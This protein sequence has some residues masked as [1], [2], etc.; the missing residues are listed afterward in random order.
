[1]ARKATRN[2]QGGGTIRQRSDG[3]WEARY[4]VGKDPGTGKQLQK[5]IYGDSQAEV[6]RLLTAALREIDKGTYIPPQK[7][8]LSNWLDTWL[9]EYV[10]NSVKPNTY[11]AYKAQV[12]K[13]IKPALGATEIQAL[14]PHSIQTFYNQ[15]LAEGQQVKVKDD[16]K[17]VHVENRPMSPK[18]VHNIHGVLTKALSVATRL[19]Y[20]HANPA[21]ACELPRQV[22]KTVQP[23]NEADIKRFL[24]DL[25]NDPYKNLFVAALFTGLR[26]AELLGLQ[27]S[28]VDFDAGTIMV[29]K[30]LLKI[31]EKNGPYML[32][33]T[34]TDNIR[35][36]TPA[37][38]VMASL[39]AE[40]VRQT[41]N[42]L[43]SYGAFSNPD[44]LVFTDDNG[45]H[46][47]ARTVVKHFKAIVTRLGI[48]EKRFHDLR[49]SYATMALK[50]GDS[51]K[52][53]QTNLGHSTS[54]ITLDL[55]S[56]VTAEMKKASA[57]RMEG[58]IQSVKKA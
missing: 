28:C 31:K 43:K 55:Y 2:A 1:M 51:I 24:A 7:M 32:A 14:K 22:K 33:N 5:S 8:K 41:E 15:M 17:V 57:D 25:E 23:L 40:R 54:T 47:V 21:D 46:L 35:L 56:H 49:H 37:P 20:I 16:A 11:R 10:E 42:Q 48:P 30:Q 19:G 44:S 29:N 12:E 9:K 18:S 58:F 26:Q 50:S 4:T 39:R 6:R 3:R 52:D 53:V 13:H 27:W 36:I 38:T 45:K 34:K